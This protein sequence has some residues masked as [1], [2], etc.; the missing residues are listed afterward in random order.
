MTEATSA[1][2]A[3]ERVS[4]RLRP[5]T[6]RILAAVPGPRSLG[7]LVWALVPWLN[8][9]ANLLLDTGSRSAIWEQ[10]RALVVIN[11]ATLSLA[12]VITLWGAQR[13]A[14]T[15]TFPCHQGRAASARAASKRRTLVGLP[16]VGAPTRTSAVSC[17]LS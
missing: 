11:Y 16:T 5:L 3:N 17:A 6:E 12:I 7:I 8:F 4:A 2:R 15:G 9:G 1:R 14:R 13:I 10:R